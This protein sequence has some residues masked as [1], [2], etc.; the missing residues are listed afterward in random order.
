MHAYVVSYSKYII[1]ISL[2]LYAAAALFG[3]LLRRREGRRVPEGLQ[4]LLIPWITF[5]GYLTIGILQEELPLMLLFWSLQTILMQLYIAVYRHTFEEA[6]MQILLDSCLLLSVGLLIIARMD[7]RSAVKQGVIASVGLFLVFLIAY[8]RHRIPGLGKLAFL[9]ALLGLGALGTVLFLGSTTLGAKITYT[10]AGMTFQPSEFVK[11]LYPVFLAGALGTRHLKGWRVLL[12]A[13]VA[14]GHVGI[15]ILSTDLGSALIFYVVFLLVL[16]LATGRGSYVA[17]GLLLGGAGAAACFLLFE[18]IR[19]RVEVFIDPFTSIDNNGYQIAQSLFAISFGG[20]WG[21]GLTQG[22]PQKI[23]FVM[24]DF[25]FAAIAEEMGLIA[26]GCI[27]AV[28][29]LLFIG[30]VLTALESREYYT[31]RFLELLLFGI[32]VSFIFQTFL[33]VGGETKS[34]PLTGVTLPLVS[35]GGS[36]IL[37]TLIMF[38]I[39]DAASMLIIERRRMFTERFSAEEAAQQEAAQREAAMRS[40]GPAMQ[41]QAATGSGMAGGSGRQQEMSQPRRLWRPQ[42][43]AQPG[44]PAQTGRPG[45]Q[46]QS[47]SAVQYEDL[48]QYDLNRIG[49]DYEDYMDP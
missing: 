25:I 9:W 45:G 23:P 43:G 40:A 38:G 6:D 27:L 15:L 29:L 14:A 21:A 34:I 31:D 30:I 33:T 17:A 47:R 39:A 41:R 28:C 46:P 1:A 5:N 13:I 8:L 26:G 3:M 20:L 10:I 35:Y 22:A 32:G 16:Y 49:S 18:H 24:M 48:D 4:C 19:V 44:R 12:S 7:M 11:I 37:C 36:S 2:A 42:R